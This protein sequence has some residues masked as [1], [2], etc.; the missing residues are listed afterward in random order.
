MNTNRIDT[1]YDIL[2]ASMGN[3][4]LIIIPPPEYRFE[5]EPLANAAVAL[6]KQLNRLPISA[7][8]KSTVVQLATE[9]MLQAEQN[10][11]KLGVEAYCDFLKVL[12][13]ETIAEL[14]AVQ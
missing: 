10:A 14:D 1:V 13:P 11:V 8:E 9:L 12:T 7:T 4:G 3:E 2:S 6:V 5:C